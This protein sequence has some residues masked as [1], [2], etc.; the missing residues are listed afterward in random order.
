MAEEAGHPAEREEKAKEQS[1]RGPLWFVVL[2]VLALGGVVEVIVYGY[3]D[4]PGWT[5]VAD[6]KFWDYLALL[7]VPAALALGVYWLNRRQDERERKA[8]AVRERER[9]ATEEARKARELE[10]EDQRA[11]G[12][13]LQAYLDHMSQLLT[14]KERPLH[15]AQV[16]DSLS[17]VA[18]ARTLA[19]LMRLS[20]ERKGS[21]VRFLYELGLIIKD[22]PIVDLQQADL[23]GTIL[24]SV[25]LRGVIL[26][27]TSL[28]GADLSGA[29][30]SGVGLMEANLRRAY[31]WRANLNGAFLHKASLK[32]ADLSGTILSGIK[33]KDISSLERG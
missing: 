13:A 12:A 9:E 3:L 30:L 14:D 22:R 4:R 6:K 20:G 21:V 31:L 19:V 2:T 26:R 28:K 17:T 15:R 18:R 10:V 7:I 29:D 32:G 33:G 24:R 23:S 11:Q 8:D 25:I 5:G 27:G 16:G 1:G